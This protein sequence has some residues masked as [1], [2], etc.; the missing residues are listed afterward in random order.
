MSSVADIKQF[1]VLVNF[2]DFNKLVSFTYFKYLISFSFFL[3]SGLPP[4]LLFLFKYVLLVQV[5]ASGYFVV[6]VFVIFMNVISLTYYLRIIKTILFEEKNVLSSIKLKYIN[7]KFDKDMFN[8]KKMLID[9]NLYLIFILFFSIY[10]F[11][12]FSDIE[13]FI[14][15]TSESYFVAELVF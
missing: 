3:I 9:F 8:E 5:L 4:F 13:V 15:Y 12:Y 14:A 6:V 1:N 7:D 11:V 10:L 2:S